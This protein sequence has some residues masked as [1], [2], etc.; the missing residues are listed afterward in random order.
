MEGL[1]R[2]AVEGRLPHDAMVVAIEGGRTSSVME[3][4]E[5]ATILNAPPTVQPVIPAAKP[6]TD[7]TGGLIPYKNVPALIGYYV[8]VFSLIPGAALLL[9]PA[10][11]VLGVAGLKR[12]RA[13]PAA[14]GVVHAWIAIIG[15]SL[16]FLGN[17]GVILFLE[18]AEM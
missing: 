9:G 17:A 5:L 10:A 18:F 1:R 16:T 15:G 2:W 12:Y 7:A 8:A 4:P 3:F 13:S 14:R 6:E 11:V